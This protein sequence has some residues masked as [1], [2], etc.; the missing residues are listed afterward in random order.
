MNSLAL[1]INNVNN[2]IE[3]SNDDCDDNRNE[4]NF[5]F[6]GKSNTRDHNLT[7][8]FKGVGKRQIEKVGFIEFVSYIFIFILNW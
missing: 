1:K 6:V 4:S 8:R 7:L 3:L 5:S 2:K